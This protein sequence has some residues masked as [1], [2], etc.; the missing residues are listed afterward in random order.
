MFFDYIK[1]KANIDTHKTDFGFVTYEVGDSILYIHD[2]YVVPSKRKSGEGRKML[3]FLLT[4][5]KERNIK[6]LSS[7]V[8]LGTNNLEDA[9][10]AQLSLGFV[11]TSAN[12]KEITLMREV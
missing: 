6:A 12:E 4:L 1:E 11:V 2:S 3:E 9:L 5:A 8:Q 7:N 10:M